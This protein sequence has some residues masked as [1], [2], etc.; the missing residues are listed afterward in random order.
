MPTTIAGTGL[1]ARLGAIG[2]AVLTMFAVASL[3]ACSTA[4]SPSAT[5]TPFASAT[6]V[7]ATPT[8]TVTH[9]ADATRTARTTTPRATRS[10][11]PTARASASR[12]PTAAPATGGGGTAGFQ[13]ATL[14]W[15]GLAAILAGAGSIAYRRKV[16]R[17][18]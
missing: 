6:S 4:S 14:L 8:T 13:H 15:L 12:F 2:C 9:T 5:P 16:I 3:S 17:D 11:S 7:S 10:P 18:R 1:R